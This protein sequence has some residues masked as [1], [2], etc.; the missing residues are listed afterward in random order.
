MFHSTHKSHPSVS[1]AD[2]SF[3]A[4]VP[5]VE[6]RSRCLRWASRKRLPATFFRTVGW[7]LGP[8]RTNLFRICAGSQRKAGNGNPSINHP[9]MGPPGC[10]PTSTY[11]RCVGIHFGP[12]M[13]GWM[14]GAFGFETTADICPSRLGRSVV[15]S[16]KLA[17]VF[18]SVPLPRPAVFLVSDDHC[19][20][21]QPSRA[22]MAS[23]LVSSSWIRGRSMAHL[24][25][26]PESLSSRRA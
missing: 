18:P 25:Y 10:Y 24:E 22:L 2:V 13:D 21:S 15:D 6:L 1:L 12:W 20:A 14:C 8:G 3:S 5:I 23:L 9:I 7:C 11:N 17:S 16:L 19:F 4:S 26:H